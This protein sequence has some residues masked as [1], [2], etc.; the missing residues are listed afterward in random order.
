MMRAMTAVSSL[1]ESSARKG[2][3]M[4]EKLLAAI[5]TYDRLRG[6]GYP[7][8]DALMAA[9]TTNPHVSRT[10]LTNAINGRERV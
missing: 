4:S 5:A 10:D 9:L 3:K 7:R 6:F 8:G 1:L 2:G